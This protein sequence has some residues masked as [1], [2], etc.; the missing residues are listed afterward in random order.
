MGHAQAGPRQ[1][2]HQHPLLGQL[3]RP[4][5]VQGD[6][7]AALFFPR[8]QVLHLKALARARPPCEADDPLPR[9]PEQQIQAVGCL[10]ADHQGAGGGLPRPVKD[11]QSGHGGHR[12]GAEKLQHRGA[13]HQLPGRQALPVK[14]A[15][16]DLLGDVVLKVGQQ[17]LI[18]LIQGGGVGEHQTALFK[19]LQPQFPEHAQQREFRPRPLQPGPD[20]HLG[21]LQLG[22]LPPRPAGRPVPAGPPSPGCAQTPP[23]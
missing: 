6:K 20:G 5:P 19:L 21:G 15:G 16:G 3:L 8:H 9:L 4:L 12:P 10:L 18:L 2:G 22:G 1:P 7:H 11:P 13:Q 14:E 17:L 23:G